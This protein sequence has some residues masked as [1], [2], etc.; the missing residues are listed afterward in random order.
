MTSQQPKLGKDL[1]YSGKQ[2]GH[3]KRSGGRQAG[4]LKQH[5]VQQNDGSKQRSGQQNGPKPQSSC[6]EKHPQC[7]NVCEPAPPS[8]FVKVPKPTFKESQQELLR[9][10]RYLHSN[11]RSSC[12]PIGSAGR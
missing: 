4:G 8:T 7:S 5:P 1:L 10:L 3:S 9:F 11:N 2:C 12:G 6:R